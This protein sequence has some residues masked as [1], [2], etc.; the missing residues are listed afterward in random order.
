MT[1][2]MKLQSVIARAL[3]DDEHG[4]M[5]SLDLSSAFDMVN[6]RLLFERLNIIGHTSDMVSVISAWLTWRYFYVSVGGKNYYIV[7]F[8]VGTIQG[9]I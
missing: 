6:V 8:G 7:H 2:R 3:N 5:L 1:A 9:S 4:L